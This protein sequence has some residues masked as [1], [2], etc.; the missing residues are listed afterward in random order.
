MT[1]SQRVTWTAFAILAMFL[2]VLVTLWERLFS[3]SLELFWL[4]GFDSL[5]KY[6]HMESWNSIG[7]KLCLLL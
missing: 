2:L 1:D 3:G 4:A 5:S 7:F 6:E